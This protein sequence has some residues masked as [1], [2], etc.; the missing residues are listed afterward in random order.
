MFN[1]KKHI[2]FF[3]FQP[4]DIIRYFRFRWFKT[5][6]HS[7]SY[8]TF[9]WPGEKKRKMHFQKLYTRFVSSNI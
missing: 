4:S 9:H 5:L 6:G 3:W 2:I 8:N 7:I 1:L